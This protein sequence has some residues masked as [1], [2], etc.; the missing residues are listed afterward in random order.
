MTELKYEEPVVISRAD[1]KARRLKTYFTGNPCNKGHIER[2]Y[3]SGKS[4][5]SCVKQSK[6]EILLEVRKCKNR[7]YTKKWRANKERPLFS[8]RELTKIWRKENSEELERQR[9]ARRI[10]SALKW[11]SKNLDKQKESSRNWCKRNV[12][13]CRTRAQNRRARKKNAIGRFC[14]KHIHDLYVKQKILCAACPADLFEYPP[15][16]DHIMPLVLGG[17]NWPSNIQ[18]LCPACNLS[19]N[20]KHPKLWCEEIGKPEIWTKWLEQN[21]ESCYQEAS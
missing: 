9:K 1:A 14:T 2:R 10:E 19:K 17:S 16:I 7:E 6:N 8:K 15:H 3:V 11:R 20:A 18:L 21:K 4:C 13:K 12:D 5:I